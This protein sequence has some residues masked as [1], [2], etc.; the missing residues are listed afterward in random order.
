MT[1]HFLDENQETIR[2]F[3]KHENDF[4]KI[5]QFFHENPELSKKEFTTSDKI[6]ELLNE[7]GIKTD[8]SFLETGVIGLIKKGT[9]HKR[10]G[11]RADIDA[12]PIDE[13]TN[14]PYKSR[15]EGIMH[16]CGHDGHLSMLL[17]AAKYL[18]EVADFDGEILL[19]FQPNE[20]D[21]AGARDLI[22]AGLF[23]QYPVD[24]VYA[25]HNF[26]GAEVGTLLITDGPQMAGTVGIEID[27][28]GIGCHAAH[29]YKGVDPIVTAAQVIVALQS[30][31]TRNMPATDSV[32]ITIGSIHGGSAHNIIPETV[33][34][35]GTLRY[36]DPKIRDLTK[37]RIREITEGICAAFGATADI[38]LDDGYIATVNHD[39]ESEIALKAA[40]TLFKPEAI[41]TVKTP[42]MG[43]EDFGFMLADQK[44]AYFYIGNGEDS[45]TNKLH[46]AG[47]DFHDQNL[48]YGGVYW[49]ILAQYYLNNADR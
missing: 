21:S 31:P 11:L 7:W 36:F 27:I 20:E 1:F 19:I 29:P 33:K 39:K 44:G 8:R 28:H 40:Q 49:A 18:Q 38:R 23:N 17:F 48:L 9:S 3:K 47:F 41:A 14:L 2:W 24:A 13:K 4:I 30:I 26:P 46:N 15:N 35:T 12:L 42:S 16:A 32:I 6:N 10:V 34:L 37:K 22:N 5:R 45:A 43:A 25:M